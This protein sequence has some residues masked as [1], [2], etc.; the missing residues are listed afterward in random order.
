M[1]ARLGPDMTE[2]RLRCILKRRYDSSMKAIDQV[3]GAGI[4]IDGTV[5]IDWQ[6]SQK[7]G[8]SPRATITYTYVG[9]DGKRHKGSV[10]SKRI[11]EGGYDRRSAAIADALN[12]SPEF[13]RLIYDAREQGVDA[14]QGADLSRG[15]S[16][17][18]VY[19]GESG[20]EAQEK[21]LRRLGYDIDTVSSSGRDEVVSIR[22]KTDSKDTGSRNRKPAKRAKTARKGSGKAV[23]SKS[24]LSDYEEA[25]RMLGEEEWRNIDRYLSTRPDL[26]L[27]DVIYSQKGWKEYEKW[28][29]SQK[30]GR[31]KRRWPSAISRT[32]RPRPDGGYGRKPTPI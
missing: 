7:N 21:T 30:K 20:S 5:K 2:G 19:T 6:N 26:Y 11:T 17:L 27:N 23:G 31:S 28:R 8:Y 14:G 3:S 29:D 10:K 24:I 4:P 1:V 16:V 18:P 25:R 13:S 32:I 12:N 9:R 22:R 15:R